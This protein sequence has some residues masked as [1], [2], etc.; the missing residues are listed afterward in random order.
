MGDSVHL[1]L[2]GVPGQILPAVRVSSAAQGWLVGEIMS[3]P[4]DKTLITATVTETGAS[5]VLRAE[6]GE[7]RSGVLSAGELWSLVR[8]KPSTWDGKPKAQ[9]VGS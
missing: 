8:T 7:V 3:K 4:P 5:F 6:D 2:F 1:G 9:E